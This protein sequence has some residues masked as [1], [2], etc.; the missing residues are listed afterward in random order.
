LGGCCHLTDCD[1][2]EFHSWFSKTH[3]ITGMHTDSFLHA[4]AI[5]EGAEGAVIEQYQFVAIM[6]ECAVSSGN[7]GKTFWQRDVTGG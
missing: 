7:S 4:L 5:Y 3:A 2:R 1:E 6:H